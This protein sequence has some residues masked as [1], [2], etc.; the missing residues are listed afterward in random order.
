M[1]GINLQPTLLGNNVMLK[2]L[3]EEDFDALY[4]V[5]CDPEIWAMHPNK[6][7]YK[8]D[9]FQNFFKGALE[10]G[11]ALKIIDVHNRQV[12]GCSRF[13]E[14]DQKGKTIF[15]GYSFFAKRCWGQH[16]NTEAKKLMLEYIFQFV[17]KVFFHVGAENLRSQKAMEKLGARKIGE[18]EVAYYGEP[19]RSNFT[20][21][22]KKEKWRSINA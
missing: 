17:D 4:A 2:P 5:A 6:N 15:I 18:E 22:I 12:I 1:M 8:K 7:R 20:Y 10:S 3:L 21:E 16:Y 11:G 14:Y 13:Y 19:V 9:V